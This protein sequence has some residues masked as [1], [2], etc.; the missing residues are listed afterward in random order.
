M[1]ESTR[2]LLAD[3]YETRGSCRSAV[4]KVPAVI[5]IA[6]TEMH[7][8]GTSVVV[9]DANRLGD[10]ILKAAQTIEAQEDALLPLRER[11]TELEERLA[12]YAK[13]TAQLTAA[14]EELVETLRAEL[15]KKNELCTSDEVIVTSEH[16]KRAL[17]LLERS[18]AS[19]GGPQVA[20]QWVDP[21]LFQPETLLARVIA[22]DECIQQFR[23][24]L[25][26]PSSLST[27]TP[28][29]ELQ[30]PSEP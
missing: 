9:M 20:A 8:A 1:T 28:A 25:S 10:Q 13:L 26:F 23:E 14:S 4:Q 29:A 12:Q 7:P 17:R 16:R 5:Q 11:I 21:A 19:F 18:A 27:T 2:P 15:A 3:L 24:Q 30:K 22:A 6:A